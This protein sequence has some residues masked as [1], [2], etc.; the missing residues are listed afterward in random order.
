MKATKL[1]MAAVIA[2]CI[3]AAVP[4]QAQKSTYYSGDKGNKEI[5]GSVQIMD[6]SITDLRNQVKDLENIQEKLHR[7]YSK[8][9]SDT[10]H[11]K[12]FLVN[13]SLLASYRIK[14]NSM[15]QQ[16]IS[17]ISVAASKDK[18]EI[19]QFASR[20]PREFTNGY[21]TITYA[22]NLSNGYNNKAPSDGKEL[23][24][25]I[26][27]AGFVNPVTATVTSVNGP[28]N[29]SKEFTVLARGKSMEFTLPCYG[30]YKTVFT[31]GRT[32]R[33]VVKTVA[34]NRDYY[35]GDKRF[36]YTATLMP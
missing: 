8:D 29:F 18:Q 16:K 33:C 26:E 31:D 35:K 22:S 28:Q 7:K 4:V 12:M 36:D 30:D 24:G 14:L 27:N 13:D 3:M 23:T 15:E 17:F 1:I 2:M 5:I 9:T 32:V 34:P 6:Q 19:I 10:F 11:H 21:A 25:I 20:N